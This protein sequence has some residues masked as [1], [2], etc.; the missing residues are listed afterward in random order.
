ML[1]AIPSHMKLYTVAEV[2]AEK[3]WRGRRLNPCVSL[4]V[5]SALNPYLNE[6]PLPALCTRLNPSSSFINFA[7]KGT[8][9]QQHW[10]HINKKH[11]G[12]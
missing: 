4:N 5:L 12:A 7:D 2:A 1:L 9:G 3:S 10:Q 11:G 8:C 6:P